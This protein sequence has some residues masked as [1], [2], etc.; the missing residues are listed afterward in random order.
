GWKSA[1]SVPLHAQ[2]RNVGALTCFSLSERPLPESDLGLLETIADQ[3]AVAVENARLYAESRDLAALE[4]RSRLARELHDSVTQ[5]LFTLTLHARTAQMAAEREELNPDGPLAASLVQLREL[6]QGALAE[7]RALIF[8][9]RPGAL[10]EEGLVA[11]LEKH[12]AAVSAREDI[13][14]R[15]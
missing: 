9:L 3:V 12:A 1:T 15:I 6:T 4:E 11:A 2:G 5:A 8:E 13:V 10:S 7:M 14:I